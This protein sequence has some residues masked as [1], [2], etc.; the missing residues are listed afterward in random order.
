M[1]PSTE[2][3]RSPQRRKPRGRSASLAVVVL[4]IVVGALMFV[5]VGYVPAWLEASDDAQAA[6]GLALRLLGFAALLAAGAL[7]MRR[8]RGR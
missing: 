6:V 3:G 8:S 5:A 7:M 1:P 4:L 2:N